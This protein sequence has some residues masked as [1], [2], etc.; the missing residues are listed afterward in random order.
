[1]KFIPTEFDGLVLIEPSIFEDERGYFFESFN[2][3]RFQDGMKE[4]DL[5]APEFVQDNHSCSTKG[6][7][8]GLHFQRPPFGQGKLVRVVKGSAFDVAVDIRPESRTYG[9]W[10]GTHLNAIQHRM[11]WI[12]EGF[13]HGFQALEDD[14]HFLYKTTSFYEPGSEGCIRWDDPDIGIQ[15]PI[16]NP[17]LNP[18]DATAPFFS[19]KT[20]I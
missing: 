19:A 8:R 3:R 14:T 6:V 4:L 12:P 2:A 11:L 9:K 17:I 13:A 18:K 16:D 1:M 15:W 20:G 7:L 10:F 5:L